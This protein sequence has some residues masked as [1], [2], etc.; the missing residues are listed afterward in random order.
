MPAGRSLRVSFRTFGCKLNQAETEALADGFSAAGAVVVG[1][2]ELADLVVF[3]TCTVTSKAEQKAR[4]EMRL[5]LRR[6]PEA[7]AIA[8]GCYAELE[9]EAVAAVAPR[10]VVV[11]GSRKG[12]VVGMASGLVAARLEGLDPLDELRRLA[13]LAAGREA[14]PFAF[15]P[16]DALFHSRP[17]LKVQDGCD[18]RCAYCR[19][20]LARGHSVSLEPD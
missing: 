8:T 15:A 19:V 1:P 11:P 13:A 4:R 16:G 6:N 7:V 2:G 18:N 3:N 20:C 10:C 17:Q 12:S 14:D 9:P 5:A